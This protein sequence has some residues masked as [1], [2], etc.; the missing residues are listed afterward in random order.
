MYIAANQIFWVFFHEKVKIFLMDHGFFSDE[1]QLI[2]EITN[3]FRSPET[4]QKKRYILCL[5]C[6]F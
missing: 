5:G 3:D 2:E 1:E 4:C 6:I